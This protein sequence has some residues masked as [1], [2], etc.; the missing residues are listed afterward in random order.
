MNALLCGMMLL[1]PQAEAPS[2]LVSR[3]I[4]YYYD[5]RTLSGSIVLTQRT[6]KNQVQI[7]TKLQFEKP[8]RFYLHQRL[9][10]AYGQ[11]DWLVTSDGNS[12]TYDPPRG[13]EGTRLMESCWQNG[14]MFSHRNIYQAVVDSIGDRSCPL[15]LI[16]GRKE[17]LEFRR[18]Q[19]ATL[20]KLGEA[21]VG[22]VDATV[23][24]G[25]YRD[26]GRAP[27]SGTYEMYIDASGQLRRYIERETVAV[28]V[29]RQDVI[30][31]VESVWDVS[32]VKDGPV[33]QG[34]FKVVK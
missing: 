2:A 20:D 10:A 24:G 7:V 23:V 9:N 15:D 26:Y 12:F 33:D 22:D 4:A 1:A 34:L 5:A 8:N 25:K 28:K 18:L 30:Q 17:D 31:Q 11:R 27:V 16:I 6:E 19:W 29:N 14:I 21:K 32:I 3:M 13:V